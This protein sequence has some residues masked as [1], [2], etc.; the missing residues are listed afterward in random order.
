VPIATRPAMPALSR[1]AQSSR[2]R[3]CVVCMGASFS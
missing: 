2:E 3:S 1:R